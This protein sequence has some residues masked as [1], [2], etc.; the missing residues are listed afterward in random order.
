MEGK[1]WFVY[2][3]QCCDGTIYTGITNDLQARIK[4]HNSGKGAKYTRSR[5]PVVLKAYWSFGLKSEAA[6]AEYAFKQLSRMEKMKMI[7]DYKKNLA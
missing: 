1:T 3:V 4:K 5:T 6:K 2:M 7:R